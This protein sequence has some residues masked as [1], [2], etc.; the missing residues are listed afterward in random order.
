M[1]H[2]PRAARRADFPQL[3]HPSNNGALKL[4]Q[5]VGA[6]NKATRD[7]HQPCDNCF[8]IHSLVVVASW[9]HPGHT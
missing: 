3:I 2:V 5:P 6:D 4:S 9:F 1:A 8:I 7:P